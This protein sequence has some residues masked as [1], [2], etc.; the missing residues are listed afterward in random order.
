MRFRERPLLGCQTDRVQRGRHHGQEGH[1]LFR[2]Q[3]TKRSHIEARHQD[4]CSAREQHRAQ[5]HVPIGNRF[6]N[7]GA[8][9]AAPDF[10]ARTVCDFGNVP[11]S[12][13]KQTAFSAGGTM[14]RKVTLS[15][16][17]SLQ[18]AATS[19][20]GIRTSV[21]PVSNTGLR[22]TFRSEI[23][24]LIL[25]PAAPLLISPPEPYAISG[26]SLARLPN[27]PRSARAA[28]WAGRSRS[29][30][31]PAYKAQPHRSAAS[32]RVFRP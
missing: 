7:S 5:D 14:G 26:T 2:H 8:S 28:P 12:A 22:I 3:L 1:A 4:E 23:A 15:S 20:R 11:C 19:K 30:P 10:A 16:A 9:G 31:P 27:R 32:G 6:A 24:L 21:P 29:L 13:A 25:A 18:S 17:T